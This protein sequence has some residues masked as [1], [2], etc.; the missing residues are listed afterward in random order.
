MGNMPRNFLA[1]VG[2]GTGLTLDSMSMWRYEQQRGNG[3]R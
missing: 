2:L 1:R 3:H